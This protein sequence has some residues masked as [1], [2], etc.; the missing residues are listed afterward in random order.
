MRLLTWSSTKYILLPFFIFAVF[1]LAS[2]SCNRNGQG[3]NFKYSGG[4]LSLA[5]TTEPATFAVR[6]VVDY[7]S[8]LLLN[9]IYEG[10]VHLDPITLKVIPGLASSW[11]VS[12]DGKTIHFHL[13]DDVYF[14][15]HPQFPE[16]LKLTPEDVIY[17]IELACSPLNNKASYAYMSIYKDI[18]KGADDFYN[19]STTS[20]EG[21]S[22]HGNTITFELLE[23]D[24]N[25]PEKLAQTQARIVS[26]KIHEAGYE[27]DLIG[28]GPF[29]FS[30]YQEVNGLNNIILTKNEYYY[31][32]DKVGNKLP[33]LDS[34]IFK[35]I[36]N[37]TPQ[38]EMFENGELCMVEGLS[39]QEV[40]AMLGEG[41]IDEFNGT[42]P[43]L[44]LVR[45][46]LLATQFYQFNLEKEIFQDVRVRKA[47]NYAIDREA[48]VQNVLHN[49]AYSA[50]VRGIIPPDA[51]NGYDSK[52]T[53]S[54]GYNYQPDL[55]RKLL[56]QAGY[57]DGKGFPE[58]SIKFSNN[59]I[60]PLVADEIANQLRNILNI[61][62]SLDG[63]SFQDLISDQEEGEGALYKTSWYADY[64]SPENFLN[65]AYS[66]SIPD[67]SHKARHT[68][69]SRYSNPRF[70][71][72]LDDAR[73]AK[74]IVEE[75]EYYAV[76]ERILMED[77]PYIILWYEE[78]I[79]IVYS[80]VRN[81]HFNQMDYYSFKEVYL[82]EWTNK[83][84]EER[85]KL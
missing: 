14:H 73:S 15:P 51:F 11:E 42:P 67:A 19:K 46:P 1:Y 61:N 32:K 10:L 80:K 26:K 35:V 48:I 71:Q 66:K 43:N 33:Y 49:Q 13:R 4:T 58:F 65:Q 85:S 12:E 31:Q 36:E 57:P 55:A 56:A 7:Y 79:K 9:Q 81:L 8:S 2:T 64:Y 54:Y 84:W 5:I 38:L 60:H 39:P 75:Y 3:K 40:S 68:N 18:L 27:T 63:M 29:K 20:I 22:F 28:T 50:G 69:Y 62:V 37:T 25:L 16:R 52:A 78:T 70:D 72:A 77:A 6:N 76:A 23:R 44:I 82:K 30:G 45:K 21:L 17:S 83:E 41:K 53:Q 24:N 59:S 74:D 34:L 47:I